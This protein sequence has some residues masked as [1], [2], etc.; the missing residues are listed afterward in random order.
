MKHLKRLLAVCAV[1]SMSFAATACGDEES[2]GGRTKS[3]DDVSIEL[4]A[5]ESMLDSDE[6]ESL[7]GK[8]V[9]WM[10]TYDLN[11]K[12]NQDRSVALSLF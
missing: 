2:T 5:A 1:L 9:Y 7:K 12:D 8:K 6:T 11:P 10:A 4:S 3:E